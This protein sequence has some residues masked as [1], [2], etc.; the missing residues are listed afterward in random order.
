MMLH[1]DIVLHEIILLLITCN[2]IN[3]RM[4]KGTCLYLFYI[5]PNKV[6]QSYSGGTNK[7]DYIKMQHIL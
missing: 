5:Q 1:H 4:A 6:I 7:I 2:F 3:F